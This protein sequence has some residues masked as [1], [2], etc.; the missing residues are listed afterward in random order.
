MVGNA[1]EY[2][3]SAAVMLRI[4]AAADDSLLAIL[5][6]SKFGI[7]ITAIVNM[8]ATTISS[9]IK[10]KPLS[11]RSLFP[12]VQAPDDDKSI[13]GWH[14]QGRSLPGFRR[15]LPKRPGTTSPPGSRIDKIRQSEGDLRRLVSAREKKRS[16]GLLRCS[17]SIYFVRFRKNDSY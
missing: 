14:S 13:Y 9:S 17:H 3:A 8:M 1:E 4:E 6:L 15:V 7:A 16:I 12:K 5:A 2:A 11:L 10:E